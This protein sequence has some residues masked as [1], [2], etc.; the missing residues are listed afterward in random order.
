MAQVRSRVRSAGLRPQLEHLFSLRVQKTQAANKQQESSTPPF[1]SLHLSL[2]L[3]LSLLW[4]LRERCKLGWSLN[5]A[6]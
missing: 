3:S 6:N 4:Y 2:S 1:T 5:E